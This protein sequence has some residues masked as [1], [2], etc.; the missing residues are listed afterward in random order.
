V[1][2]VTVGLAV[3]GVVAYAF[4][5]RHEGQVGEAPPAETAAAPAVGPTE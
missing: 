2:V 4:A 3:A 1:L 5:P